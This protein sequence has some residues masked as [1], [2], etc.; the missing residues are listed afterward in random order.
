MTKGQI[1]N[2]LEEIRKNV[3]LLSPELRT[4]LC[5]TALTGAIDTLK[6]AWTQPYYFTFG[7]D[8]QYPFP[9]RYMVVYAVEE[10][11]AVQIF[12]KHHPNRPGSDAYNAAFCYS[13]SKWEKEIKDYYKNEE[14][15]EILNA[16]AAESK[17]VFVLSP[18]ER[19]K[20]YREVWKEYVIENVREKAEE[21]GKELS[22]ED[23]ARIA[24]RYVNGGEYNCNLSYWD[25]L[26]NLIAETERK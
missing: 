10:H 4:G 13:Q 14:P 7:S 11:E 3:E 18:E 5:I 21:D 24:D 22:E 15:A 2:Q 17:P 19:E 9:N 6:D 23:I 8:E 20:I 12:M 16:P 25:N 1:V 26:D